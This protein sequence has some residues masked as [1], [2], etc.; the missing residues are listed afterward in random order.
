MVLVG[1]GVVDWF[2]VVEGLGDL[3]SYAGEGFGGGAFY[4]AFVDVGEGL[5][6]D[7]GYCV[8]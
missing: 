7:F 4:D 1:G 2:C 5:V 6:D 3:H 8:S